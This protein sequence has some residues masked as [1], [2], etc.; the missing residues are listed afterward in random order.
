MQVHTVCYSNMSTTSNFHVLQV[1][2]ELL[3]QE[4]FFPKNL[5][6]FVLSVN[7]I[8]TLESDLAQNMKSNATF[9]EFDFE[10]NRNSLCML[11]VTQLDNNDFRIQ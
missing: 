10:M 9:L 6:S 2:I 4:Q 1:D 5:F 7:F 3:F 8:V 11:T